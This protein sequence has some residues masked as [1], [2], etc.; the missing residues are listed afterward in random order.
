MYT[1]VHSKYTAK[2]AARLG[3]ALK[4]PP[5][6]I[7]ELRLA[8]WFHDIGKLFTARD[9]LRKPTKLNKVE[10][11]LIKRHIDDGLNILAPIGLPELVR[12]AIQFHQERWDGKGYPYQLAGTAIPLEGRIMQI[13]DA[14]SAMTI[15]RVYREHSNYEEALGEIK[16]NSGSQFDPDLVAA[17]IGLFISAE[18]TA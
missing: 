3:Q 8:G 13:A 9:I 4:L 14:F 7:D 18:V 15:K 17:F 11:D 6:I 10:Y 12:N 5:E 1:Y 16:R 2:Y